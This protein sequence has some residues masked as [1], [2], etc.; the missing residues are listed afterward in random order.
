LRAAPEALFATQ[1]ARWTSLVAQ[2]AKDLRDTLKSFQQQGVERAVLKLA[3]VWHEDVADLFPHLVAET[4]AHVGVSA[5]ALVA[6]MNMRS[7]AV[8]EAL[9]SPFVSVDLICSRFSPG[10]APVHV[11][12]GE[13]L[14]PGR[15]ELSAGHVRALSFVM[16]YVGKG[17]EYLV[18]QRSLAEEVLGESIKR[19]NN[20]VLGINQDIACC[21]EAVGL[22]WVSTPAKSFSFHRNGLSIHRAP[23][24]SSFRLLLAIDAC[25]APEKLG[26]PLDMLRDKMLRNMSL[27][28]SHRSLLR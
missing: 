11:D 16:P 2:E 9:K 15:A 1:D 25:V 21:P 26:R 3:F 7:Q 14:V 6:D 18:H 23:S 12:Y 17:T 28:K 13:Y 8:A 20:S 22:S 4:F 27:I 24:S 5:P 19:S 10:M